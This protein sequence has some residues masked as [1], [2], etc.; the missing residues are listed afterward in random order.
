MARILKTSEQDI[1]GQFSSV[2][3]TNKVTKKAMKFQ[4]CVLLRKQESEQVNWNYACCKERKK[5]KQRIA[6]TLATNKARKPASQKAARQARITV[7]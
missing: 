5:G 1:S 7:T 6:R 4:G 3:V 2:L